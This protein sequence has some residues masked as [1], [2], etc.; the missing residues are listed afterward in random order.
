ICINGAGSIGALATWSAS[1]ILNFVI[2]NTSRSIRIEWC[3]NMGA[4]HVVD[5]HKNLKE[6]LSPLGIIVDY[7][8]I[9]YSTKKYLP[10][11]K[12]IVKPLGRIV[13][14]V[15]VEEALPFTKISKALSFSWEFMFAK[16]MHA[17]Y[18][19]SWSVI[20]N[21]IA[22]LTDS[23]VVQQ[24]VTKTLQFF[25]QGLQTAH[26]KVQSGKVIIKITL[27]MSK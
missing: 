17:F 19:Q 26:R 10:I 2:T 9:C 14:I 4:T 18:M 3:K 13:S 22:D 1:K 21:R 6:Q 12:V 27:N 23:G 25:R 8:F 20:L 7:V 24:T 5:H 15:E 11:A 16:S